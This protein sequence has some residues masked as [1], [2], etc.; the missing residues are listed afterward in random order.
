MKKY[1]DKI[2]SLNHICYIDIYNNR[3]F[4]ILT[5]QLS[6]FYHISGFGTKFCQTRTRLFKVIFDCVKKQ[7]YINGA[8]ENVTSVHKQAHNQKI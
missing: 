2:K 1:R 5:T 3:V 7:P 8:K 4:V 6:I